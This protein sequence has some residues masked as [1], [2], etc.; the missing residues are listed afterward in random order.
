MLRDAL[1]GALIVGVLLS[2]PAWGYEE[3][4]IPD[5]GSLRGSV[6]YSGTLP[7]LPPIAVK[8]N[9]DVC[10]SSKP[11]EALVVGPNNG[12]RSSVILV[13][14]IRSGKKADKEV[15]IDNHKCVFM[16]HVAAVMAGG[17][18]KIKNSDDILH[19]TRGSL[20]RSTVFNTA[21][22]RQHQQIDITSKLKRPGIVEVLCDAHTHMRGW[23]VVHDSPY[24]AVT[25][26]S[27]N[28]LIDGIPPGKY[29][30]T[31]W[32]ESWV[33]KGR[34]KD[35][36]VPYGDPIVTTKEVVI[37]PKGT[38]TVEFELKSFNPSS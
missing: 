13:E 10:G 24:F 17:K 9:Q 3:A 22:P 35:G 32:H 15:V 38:A 16:P 6:K 11:S 27:G 14:G 8:K 33:E 20:A 1:Y 28:F 21:L 36:R 30:I 19:N 23:L 37:P 12:V 7:T 31:M 2:G 5:G 4:S 34:D 29:K 26:Q 25:D 18:I